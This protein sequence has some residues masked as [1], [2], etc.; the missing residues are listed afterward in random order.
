[1]NLEA[2]NPV[3]RFLLQPPRVGLAAEQAAPATGPGRADLPGLVSRLLEAGAK[4]RLA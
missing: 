3:T 2:A 4:R 1:M